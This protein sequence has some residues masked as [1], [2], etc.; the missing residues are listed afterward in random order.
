MLMS[1][2][3]GKDR[4]ERHM[5]Q[6]EQNKEG[7]ARSNFSIVMLRKGWKP[8]AAFIKVYVLQ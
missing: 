8:E 2:M 1:A 7:T 5:K 3:E 4:Q 6:L